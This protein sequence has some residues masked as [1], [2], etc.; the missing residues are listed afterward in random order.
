QWIGAA[1]DRRTF[2]REIVVAKEKAEEASK[3]KAH[4]LSTMS[5]EIRT[6]LNAVVG[7]AYLLLQQDPKPEQIKNLQ[8]LQFSANN[9][10]ALINDIL[11]F[12]KI[13]S[14]K[15]E[16]ERIEYDIK[17]MLE[18]LYAMLEFKAIEK[19]IDLSMHISPALPVK[20]KGDPTR[21]NQIITNLVS[22]TINFT[23]TGGVKISIDEMEE[24]KKNIAVKRTVTDSGIV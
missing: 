9:L 24:T 19:N 8:T 14:S 11:D 17:L 3:A 21:L 7:I 10:L 5:H 12:S 2:E 4:F 23:E 16:I 22:S 15:I 13:E 1:I 20:V 18:R 6:P